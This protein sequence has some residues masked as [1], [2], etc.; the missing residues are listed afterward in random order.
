VVFVKAVFAIALQTA[1]SSL[2][3]KVFFVLL[4]LTIL[5]T[6]LLPDSV[7]GDATLAGEFKVRLNYSIGIITFLTG[8]AALWVGTVNIAKE[9]EGYQIHMVLT[10]PVSS[11]KLWLGKFLGVGILCLGILYLSSGWIYYRISS[12]VEGIRSELVDKAGRLWVEAEESLTKDQ[13]TM[14]GQN[15]NELK[16]YFTA[17]AN[18]EEKKQREGL[19]GV[20]SAERETVRSRL[21]PLLK[22]LTEFDE[23]RNEVLTGRKYYKWDKPDFTQ[24]AI[25]IITQRMNPREPLSEDEIQMRAVE[26]ARSMESRAGSLP[27]GQGNNKKPKYFTFN[28]LPEIKESELFHLRFR[29]YAGDSLDQVPRNTQVGIFFADEK[30]KQLTRVMPLGLRTT[31]FYTYDFPGALLKNRKSIKVGLLNYDEAGR[32][33]GKRDKP[34]ELVIQAKDG[35]NI[36]I[37][38][39]SFFSNYWR[40]ILLIGMF[41]LFLVIVGTVAG[42]CFSTP[43]AVMMSISYIIVGISVSSVLESQ[44]A[45]EVQKL[46][47]GAQKEGVLELYYKS[48]KTVMVSLETFSRM[49][50]LSSGKEISW[51]LVLKVLLYDFLLKGIPV[52]LLG[53]YALRVREMGLVIRK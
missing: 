53:L 52:I 18:E 25:K 48:L 41:V 39:T 38:Q 37:G 47:E 16:Y 32:R 43:V 8:L 4:V 10:K 34:K 44:G 13:K 35:P 29:V 28:N 9:I 7:M 21:K 33:G 3:S 42:L 1:R 45:Y 12:E 6:A 23:L 49:E 51:A 11:F 27:L 40:C 26:I 19:S 36:L 17:L 22:K 20:E 14:M 50:N 46:E 5:A 2:R 31:R 15:L 30:G 24:D